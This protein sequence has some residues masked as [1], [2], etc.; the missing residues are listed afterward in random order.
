MV[1]NLKQIW[2]QF[3]IFSAF[4]LYLVR[5]ILIAIMHGRVKT[6]NGNIY[7]EKSLRKFW[8]NFVISAILL[9]VITIILIHF[10]LH[11]VNR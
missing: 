7:K 3:T 1:E 6:R 5:Y 9:T 10:A 11:G 8:G 4:L 2:I